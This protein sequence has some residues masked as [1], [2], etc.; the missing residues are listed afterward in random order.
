MSAEPF[1]QRDADKAVDKG[2]DPNKDLTTTTEEGETADRAAS[3]VALRVAG[4]S[5][6]DIART[7]GYS[8]AHRARSAVE[9]V[10]ASTADSPEERDRVRD[11]TDRRLNR[12]L[13][14]V[15]SKATNPRDPEHLAYNA[16]ALA[17]VDRQA[18]L[19]GVDAPTQAVIHTPSAERVEEYIGK[20][21][22]F[23][24]VSLD[25]DEADIIEAEVMDD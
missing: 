5:Y 2:E 14:S 8:S 16:R 24:K 12:L 11:L 20:V 1:H 7:L 9:R 18:R 17:I 4:A 21:L 3:A 15:M 10:L 13:Q 22:A 6:S 25:N 23:A 19:H